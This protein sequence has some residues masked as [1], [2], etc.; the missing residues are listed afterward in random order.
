MQQVVVEGNIRIVWRPDEPAFGDAI[1]NSAAMVELVLPHMSGGPALVVRPV[2]RTRTFDDILPSVKRALATRLDWRRRLWMED[3][4]RPLA[5]D[6]G[7]TATT[8]ADKLL[9]VGL[10]RLGAYA[11]HLTAWPAG[12]VLTQAFRLSDA[13]VPPSPLLS[14][15]EWRKRLGSKWVARVGDDDDWMALGH[16]MPA[17]AALYAQVLADVAQPRIRMLYFR[18]NL[19]EYRHMA[20]TL[21]AGASHQHQESP[22]HPY[23]SAA[24]ELALYLPPGTGSPDMAPPRDRLRACLVA[25]LL[26]F[27]VHGQSTTELMQEMG[28]EAVNALWTEVETWIDTRSLPELM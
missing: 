2:T 18:T 21:A 19:Q 12:Q 28:R 1:E 8:P 5:A 15:A 4:P 23:F 22:L 26:G 25:A 10:D 24:S 27:N 16:I 11:R 20:R 13:N 17:S 14:R 3:R 7:T 9:A 6:V